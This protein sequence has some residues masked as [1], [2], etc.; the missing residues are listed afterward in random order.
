MALTKVTSNVITNDAITSAMIAP[1]AIDDT[2]I[3]GITTTDIAEGTNQYYTDGKV[4]TYLNVNG[5]DTATNIISAITDT[6]PITLDTLNE[7]AAALGDDPNFATTTATSLG[8]KAPLASP[9]FT[10]TAIF[11]GTVTATSV[12]TGAGAAGRNAFSSGDIRIAAPN[13]TNIGLMTVSNTLAT[14]KTD[15]YGGGSL[16]PLVLQTGANA[17]QLYLSTSGNVG[18]G[19]DNP[20]YKLHVNSGTIGVNSG[21]NQGNFGMFVQGLGAGAADARALHVRG[22]GGQTTIGGTGPT[23]VLQN[24]DGTTGNITKLSF[25]TAS[26]GEAVSINCINTDHGNF[27]GDMAFNTRGSLGYSEKLRIMANGN[28]GIGTTAPTQPLSVGSRTGANLNYLNGTAASAGTDTG[29]FVSGSTTD[30]STIKFGML[31]AN[32][33]NNNN[34]RSPIIG[35]SALSASNSYNHLYATINGIKTGTGADYNWNAGA[36]QFSTS[37]STGPIERMRIDSSGKVGI[38]TD[39]PTVELDVYGDGSSVSVGRPWGNDSYVSSGY[40]GK[41]AN[42]GGWGAGSAFMKIEDSITTGARKGT[43]IDFVTHNYGVGNQTTMSLTGNGNVGIG[44]DSPQSFAKLQV[45]AATDQHVSV[46]TNASGLTIGG[47]T[48][49]GGSGALR[50]AGSPLRL[51]GQGGGAGSGPDIEING[52]GGVSMPNQ[53]HSYGTF[54]AGNLSTDTGW[55]MVPISTVALTYNNN[56]SHGYGMTVEQAG[57]YQMTGMGLYAPASSFVYIGWCV[58]GIATYHWHSNHTIDGNHDF[59]ASIIRYCNVGDHITMEN[60][61]GRTLANQWGAGHSQYHIYKLG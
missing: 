16:V 17:N 47:L 33:A 59:V 54:G 24:A 8:L 34:A 39:A 61:N 21:Y 44:T 36:L 2:H 6:A 29:I 57:Y 56:A 60:Q 31:L 28:V 19:T 26:N 38:G 58:N 42:T 12:N 4:G 14:I 35:F 15:Y 9:S 7:L 23:I 49:N 27:Y 30:D 20:I 43:S 10:G 41:Q 32:N 45:K 3:T 1:G 51:T 18:I 48:D 52:S 11:G 50:I 37:S 13:D 22:F 5:Y 40:F 53:P 25:E 55:T 46:F